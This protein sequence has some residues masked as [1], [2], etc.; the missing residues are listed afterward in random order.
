MKF[1]TILDCPDVMVQ[2]DQYVELWYKY[3]WG[4]SERARYVRLIPP[5]QIHLC[6]LLKMRQNR[7]QRMYWIEQLA[8]GGET[9]SLYEIV[10]IKS[11]A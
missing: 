6:D 8:V 2:K 10:A 9:P 11:N 7:L 4:M 1:K 3:R 5:L